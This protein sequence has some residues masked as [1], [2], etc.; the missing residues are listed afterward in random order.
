MNV[1]N[2][3]ATKAVLSAKR[4]RWS[5]GKRK[6]NCGANLVLGP[7]IRKPR[8]GKVRGWINAQREIGP[9]LL[10]VLADFELVVALALASGWLNSLAPCWGVRLQSP[11]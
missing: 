4:M 7:Q 6:P 3:P 9:Y 11:Q 10:V 1:W 5:R 8:T 2:A